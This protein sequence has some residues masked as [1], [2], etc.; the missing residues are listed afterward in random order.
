MKEENLFGIMGFADEEAARDAAGVGKSTW[1]NTIA[2]AKAFDG[3]PEELFITMK[4]VNAQAALD[5]GESR[6]LDREWVKRAAE[7]TEKQ[8][9]KLVD[10]ELN[11]KAR[12]SDGK[13]RSVK[14]TVDMPASRKTV[15][16]EKVK[17]FAE[18]HDMPP[19]DTGRVIEAMAV[20]AT[21]GKTMLDAILHSMQRAKKIKELSESG[22]SS[23]EVLAQVILLNEDNILELA[24]ILSTKSAEEKEEAA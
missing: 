9:A 8:F 4:L 1:Y 20:E 19:E 11:G 16:E 18:A 7:L 21:G 13:E 24:E 22:L 2:I 15:I 14:M 10:E 5:L 17:E 3:L 23:D 6:R 12:R